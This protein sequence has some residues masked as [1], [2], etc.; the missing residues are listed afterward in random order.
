MIA[1]HLGAIIDESLRTATDGGAEIQ[2]RHGRLV[3]DGLCVSDAL[4]TLRRYERELVRAVTEP[5]GRV[6][7]CYRC[8]CAQTCDGRCLY[9]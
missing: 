7:R 8:R 2:I 5:G 9:E 6:V 3:V 1:R 4:R